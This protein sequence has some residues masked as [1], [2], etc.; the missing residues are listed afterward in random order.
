MNFT[1]N[2][3]L[4]VT[5]TPTTHLLRLKRFPRDEIRGY[6]TPWNQQQF[7]PEKRPFA[8]KGWP[9]LPTMAN[10]TNLCKFQGGYTPWCLACFPWKAAFFY[11]VHV[12]FC[13]AKWGIKYAT[14]AKPGTRTQKNINELS[15]EPMTQPGKVCNHPWK[16]KIN[17]SWKWR[18]G[19]YLI[20]Y[21]NL[22]IFHRCCNFSPFLKPYKF[23]LPRIILEK[24]R[25]S[26]RN[27]PTKK[28]NG[29]TNHYGLRQQGLDHLP[30][31][32]RT[33][34]PDPN[35]REIASV[36]V[37][38]TRWCFQ[39]LGVFPPKWMVYNGNPY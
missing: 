38:V 27:G 2:P 15:S 25:T 34:D 33:T 5:W 21:S 10:F 39:K 1:K 17:W 36:N 14:P 26:N 3:Q 31:D 13:Q 16:T 28:Q 35:T 18:L 11:L 32:G 7:A 12:G 23:C 37:N 29:E 9:N 6:R 22:Y 4:P 20:R 19:S 24:E 30:N 8:P